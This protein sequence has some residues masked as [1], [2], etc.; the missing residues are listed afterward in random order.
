MARKKEPEKKKKV[1]T[2]GVVGLHGS[3]TEQ[4]ISQTL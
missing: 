4:P 1:D 3:T 2:S